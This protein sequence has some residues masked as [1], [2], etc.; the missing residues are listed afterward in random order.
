MIYFMTYVRYHKVCKDVTMGKL[1][2]S[3]ICSSLYSVMVLM[4]IFFCFVKVV[5]VLGKCMY[6]SHM[7]SHITL[8]QHKH[9]LPYL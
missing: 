6:K 8:Q 2:I 7:S 3:N 1:T 5:I 9:G 4:R